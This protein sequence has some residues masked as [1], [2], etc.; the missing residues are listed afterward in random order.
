M[1]LNQNKELKKFYSIHEVAEQ[2]GVAES[3]LRY[4]ETEFPQIK[5]HKAGRNIRQ[6]SKDD[7]DA[8]KVIYNLVKVRGIKIAKAR[9]MLAKNK[10]GEQNSAEVIDRLKQIRLQLVEMRSAINQIDPDL[11]PDELPLN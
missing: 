1:A 4:W 9:E 3:L 5:P 8:I 7:I 10:E 11:L 6:Y 2:F